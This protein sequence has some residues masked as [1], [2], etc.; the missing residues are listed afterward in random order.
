MQSTREIPLTRG[1]FAVVDVEDYDLLMA[2]GPW[3]AAR[4]R[5]GGFYAER[6][7]GARITKHRVTMHE[8]IAGRK[9][10][11]HINGDSLDNRKSNLR[12]A[13]HK[14]NVR[15]RGPQRNNK[16]GYKGVVWHTKTRKWHARICVDGRT[17]SLRY[18]DD[19]ASAARAYDAAAQEHFGEFAHLN[20]PPQSSAEQE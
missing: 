2:R 4:G 3:H 16:S 19:P 14:E 8:V 13:T 10:M 9:W 12:P 1:V 11:D 7:E 6:T 5:C 17:F 15:N 20:F 18:H